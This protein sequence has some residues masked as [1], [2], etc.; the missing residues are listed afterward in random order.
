MPRRTHRHALTALLVACAGLL[1]ACSGSEGIDLAR[2]DPDYEAAYIFQQRCAACHSLD[3]VGSE[4]SAVQANGREY[5]DGPNFNERTEDYE[6]VLY[7][8]QN[9]GFSSGPMPQN[10]VVGEE[11]EKVARFVAKY[12]GRTAASE[13]PGLEAP[14][15][16][17]GG[18]VVE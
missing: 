11:A 17:P 13:A 12:A 3:V 8:I 14:E 15:G 2:D 9:G 7:A 5:K 16:D 1:A 6:D 10:I 4:G 18:G